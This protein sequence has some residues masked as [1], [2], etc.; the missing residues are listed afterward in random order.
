MKVL[1]LSRG[2][3]GGLDTV[4]SQLANVRRET[5]ILMYA[6]DP[7]NLYES[8]AYAKCYAIGWETII[9]SISGWKI[10][11]SHIKH[12]EIIHIHVTNVVIFFL[13]PLLTKKRVVVSIHRNFGVNFSDLFAEN[14]AKSFLF[15]VIR[16]V[17][18]IIYL[19]YINLLADK[20]ILP[21]STQKSDFSRWVFFQSRFNE[22]V[23]IINNFVPTSLVLQKKEKVKGKNL[24]VIFIGRLTRY[25]GFH[26]FLSVMEKLI[27]QGFNF[28][29]VG[30]GE[31]SAHI[32][33]SKN[34]L[35]ISEVNNKFIHQYLDMADILVLPSYSETF[36]I[37]ILEAMA[38]GLAVCASDLPPIREFFHDR[39]NGYL[40]RPGDRVSLF[41]AI[42]NLADNPAELNRISRSNL[43]DV[44]QFTLDRV[45]DTYKRLYHELS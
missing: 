13:W 10:L 44:D 34:I 36:G 1:H 9:P 20:V 29:I 28:V 12:S 21:T 39:R 3:S 18:L 30:H 24:T 27:D 5:S 33:V 45:L 38:R 14:K 42:K 11:R 40:F 43:S 31:L 15:R 41:N 19:N 23:T 7:T 4:V 32:P 35:Y 16:S 2:S 25:K 22:K 6:N 8:K 37:V 26:D 17:C